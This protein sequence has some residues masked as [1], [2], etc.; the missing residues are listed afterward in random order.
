MRRLRINR[1]LAIPG[2]RDEHRDSKHQ[3][4]EFIIIQ[5]PVQS[6]EKYHLHYVRF[7]PHKCPRQKK[8]VS[9]EQAEKMRVPSNAMLD[10]APPT[11]FSK[12]PDVPRVPQHLPTF[13]LAVKTS[14]YRLVEETAA[15]AES[16]GLSWL[17]SSARMYDGKCMREV[18]VHNLPFRRPSVRRIA[19]HET[20]I[21][22]GSSVSGSPT[23]GYLGGMGG[24]AGGHTP[25]SSSPGSE[26]SPQHNESPPAP[27]WP[28]EMKHHPHPHAPPHTHHHPHTPGHHP[29]PPPPPPHHAGYMPQYSWYQADPNPG[30]LTRPRNQI[31]RVYPGR[32][33]KAYGIEVRKIEAKAKKEKERPPSVDVPMCSYEVDQPG[34]FERACGPTMPTSGATA[35]HFT[36]SIIPSTFPCGRGAGGVPR[37]QALPTTSCPEL[38]AF[39]A[40]S[41]MALPASSSGDEVEGNPSGGYGWEGK[42][43]VTKFL[44]NVQT[45]LSPACYPVSYGWLRLWEDDCDYKSDGVLFKHV[46]DI[47]MYER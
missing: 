32:E 20:G 36:S 47:K 37:R 38:Q 7:H 17:P 34:L 40:S 25:G 39:H 6:I 13:P 19:R 14:V 35:T 42:V 8:T 29:P 24:G 23:T 3:S 2:L 41:R 1:S 11:F 46:W 28:G 33:T 15:A 27:S 45:H 26:M 5:L 31:R 21:G 44:V 22:G 12:G 30:L 16:C 4:T 9:P 43:W 18:H 10:V